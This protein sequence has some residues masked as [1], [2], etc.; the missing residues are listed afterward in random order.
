MAR[1]YTSE[2]LIQD[3]VPA[4]QVSADKTT[5]PS[6]SPRTF[7]GNMAKWQ[8]FEQEVRANFEKQHWNT[9]HPAIV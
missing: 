4:L 2:E 3:A 9:A 8:N 1:P 7:I 6:L 5:T